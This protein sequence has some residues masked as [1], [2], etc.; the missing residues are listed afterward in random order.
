M[1][2][3]GYFLLLIN[4]ILKYYQKLIYFESYFVNLAVIAPSHQGRQKIFQNHS[5][6]FETDFR[7]LFEVT[8]NFE[9]SSSP[10]RELEKNDFEISGEGLNL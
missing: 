10:S 8:V 4:K 5:D 2:S 1:M 3:L 7:F 6:S 9:T